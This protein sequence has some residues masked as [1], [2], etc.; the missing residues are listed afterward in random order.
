LLPGDQ[1][2]AVSLDGTKRDQIKA[3]RYVQIY[4][5]QA[6]VGGQIHYLTRRPS[7]PAEMGAYWA[8]LDHLGSIHK[9][10]PRAVYVNVIGLIYLFVGFLSSSNR[11]G[12]APFVLHFATFCL[13]ALSSTSTRQ[14][15]AT[16]IWIWRL[17]FST[18]PLCILFPH[19]S[20]L[21]CA[22]TPTRQQLF[23]T[24]RC[25]PSLVVCA[26]VVVAGRFTGCIAA[27]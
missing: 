13:A 10:T 17:L 23:A 1:L 5:E 7:Y 4:L 25:A 21:L 16:A 15:A 20:T 11:A 27:G 2:I 22:A 9:W 24:H 12:R 14:S 8:D 3:A 18:L 26:R 6:G 19:C